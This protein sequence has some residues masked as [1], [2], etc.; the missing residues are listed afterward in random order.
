M[1]TSR[2]LLLLTFVAAVPVAC[3]SPPAP[4]PEFATVSTAKSVVVAPLNLTVRAPSDLAGKGDPVWTEL[5]SYLQ[6]QDRQVAVLSP[7]S[8]ERLWLAATADLD[9][10][11]R[12]AALR[13]GYSRLAREL[14]G[15]RDFD[16]LVVPSLV[17]RPARVSG[18]HASWDGV[19]RPV[20]NAATAVHRGVGDIMGPGTDLLTGGLTGK[21]V[22]ASLHVVVL[23]PDGTRL[24]DRLGGLDVLQEARRDNTPDGALRFAA[25]AQPFSNREW[26][27]EGVERAFAGPLLTAR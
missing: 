4:A 18:L 7:L 9:L 17:M 12:Q 19:Q 1:L 25:R 27:A 22:A 24:Y 16:L 5:L 6:K 2:T 8:A 3:A 10:S 20:P 15:H 13:T 21:V 11:D 14:A 23:R 26:V